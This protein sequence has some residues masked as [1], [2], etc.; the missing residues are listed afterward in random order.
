MASKI[1]SIDSVAKF[2]N[3]RYCN[4]KSDL[5]EITEDKLENILLK[6]STSIRRTQNWTTPLS[7]F[8]T[9]LLAILT[10]DINKSFM[11][12]PKET[13]SAI[14]CLGLFISAVWTIISLIKAFLN[15]R[16]SKVESAIQR[17]KNN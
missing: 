4:T 17:I 2:I 9:I 11:G 7:V 16:E 1:T 8:V 13:W 3:Q 12:I 15:R 10:T 6:F 5:I 14:F